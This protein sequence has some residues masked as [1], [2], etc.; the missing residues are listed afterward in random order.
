MFFNYLKLTIRK[1]AKQKVLTLINIMSL[2]VGLACFCLFMLYAV[3]EFNFDRHHAN[4]DDIYRVYRW[5]EAMNDHEAEGD[6]YLP[7]PLGPAIKTEFADVVHSVRFRERW[8]EQF[9]RV[10]G[11]SSR[12]ELNFADPQV[13]EVFTFKIKAG[14]RKN[15]LKELNSLVLTEAKAQEL[16]GTENPIGKIIE[17]KLQDT[18]EAFTVSAVVAN[19]SVNSMI[20][21]SMLG[22]YQLLE[23]PTYGARNKDNWN[24][25]AFMTYVQLRPDSKLAAEPQRLTKFYQKYHP[26]DEAE[27]RKKGFWKGIGAPFTYKLQPLK[28]IHTDPTVTGGAVAPI[29]P[30]IIWLLLAIAGG[31]LLIACINFT[32]LAIGRSAGSAREVGVRKVVGSFRNQLI[33]QF[34]SESM[35]LSIL[36]AVIGVILAYMSLPYFNQ[37][38]GRELTFSLE[39]YPEMP[40][41]IVG[42]TLVVGLVAGSYPA[43]IL[44]KFKPVEVLR[45]TIKVGGSNFFTKSLVVTQFVLSVA[46]IT[47]TIVILQQITFMQSKN[48]GFNK[49]NVLV[50]NAEETDSKKVYSLFKQAISN[51]PEV[52]GVAGAELSLGAGN[53]WS[54]SGFEYNGK[55]K[56]VYEYFID[57]DYLN[58]MGMKL[59]AGRNFDPTVVSDTVTSVIINEAMVKDFG[60]TLQTAVGQRLKGYTEEESK[61][62]V[63]IGVVK[64]FHFLSFKNEVKPQLFHQFSSYVPFKYMVRIKAGDPKNTLT[65]LKAIWTK[66]VPDLPFKYSFMDE[67]LNRFYLEEERWSNIIG[68]AG[69]I[70]IF[71]A[72][73]G[74]FGLVALAVVNRT[75]EIGIRKVLG[76]SLGNIVGL[77]SANF[78]TLVF[79]AI[80]IATPVTYYFMQKLLLENFAYRID[81]HWYFFALGG[82]FAIV[83]AFLTI[84]FQAIRA[85]LANPVHSLKSE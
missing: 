71:L 28:K 57:H 20:Q 42:L 31:V 76:A 32:T 1:L 8:G 46:L 34:I 44:S 49:E 10:N 62:P 58:V 77:L 55:N 9:T 82:V 22:N 78:L 79:I 85:A 16:F 35:L 48:P 72:C 54:R 67:D 68:W 29:D 24:R 30:K 27:L 37:L 14:N 65:D 13:F 36:S 21:F 60:W 33:G 12:Q 75:K 69:G 51:Q 15:P 66:I 6:P 45:S 74:L 52:L 19:L 23:T 56:E 40:W 80:V 53:G 41:L 59:L 11:E 2:S 25:S 81:L 73:L 38:S 18:F 4:A 50:V 3:N 63:V 39:Q 47:S 17:V 7:M 70:S 84:G 61:T 26:N 5:R 64:N 83:V 43:F